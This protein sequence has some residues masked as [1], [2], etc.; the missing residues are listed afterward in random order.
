LK[1]TEPRRT[2]IKTPKKTPFDFIQRNYRE[3]RSTDPTQRWLPHPANARCICRV[4]RAKGLPENEFEDALQDVYVKA[5]GAFRERT[6]VPVDLRGMKNLCAA[7]ARNYVIDLQRKAA[8]R[9]RDGYAGLVED[10]DEY[11]PLEYGAEQRDAV[12][13]RRQLEV[14]AQL[15]R[16]G[17][18]PQ[19]GVA[20][21]EGIACR[22]TLKKIAKELGIN[23]WAVRGRM[24]TMR[25]VS[26]ARMAELGMLPSMQSLRLIVSAPR[27]IEMLRMAA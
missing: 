8:K 14:L 19:D 12:D 7:I 11:T 4:F 10:A 18:M 24:D 25:K 3:S 21:L 2:A 23:M 6:P 26:R 22:C 27:A 15:F 16:E 1:P 5:L 13:A 20:I 17:R 9:E